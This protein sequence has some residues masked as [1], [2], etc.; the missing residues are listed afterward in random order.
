MIL[1]DYSQV[2]LSAIL[3]FSKD[4]NKSDDEV[5]NLVRHVVLSN[6]L[7]YK[8]KYGK[9]YGNIVVCCDGREYWRKDV[10]QYYKGSRKK[11]RDKS[12]LNW[13]LIFDILSEMR[14]D[15]IDTFPYK[16]IHI[17][18]AEADDVIAVLA[19]WSQA[20]ELVQEGMFEEPEKMMIV[21]SDGDFLQLQKYNNVSQWSPN[22]KKLLKMS[23][24]DLHE[25]YIT[26]IVKGDSGDG[27]PNI[28][29]KDEV[30]VTD[31]IRQTPLSAKRLAEFIEVGKSACRTED[32]IRNW[33]R[34]ETLISFECIP[35]D[36]QEEIINTY[37][38]STPKRDSMKLMNYFMKHRCNLLLSELGNF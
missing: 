15:L 9:E 8:K 16:V 27:V 7:T 21:S 32:E 35:T 34:N 33:D 1:L 4:L 38:T 36:I 10:F 23:H 28:L 24:R 17:N 19:E 22:T 6:I 11:N 3:P 14:Q 26:H 25:K 13:K 18:R 37:N 30:L 2:C 12:D 5:R 29:S 31:G 20:N